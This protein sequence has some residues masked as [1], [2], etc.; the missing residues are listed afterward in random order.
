[1]KKVLVVLPTYNEADNIEPMVGA[2]FKVAAR[3]PNYEIDIL[4]VDDNSPDGTAER[5]ARL[6][7]SRAGLHLIKGCKQGLGKAY[8]RGFKHGLGLKPYFAVVMMDADFSHDPKVIP[9]LL[10]ALEA[11]ADYVIGSRYVA[12]GGTTGNWPTKRLLQSKLANFLAR[13]LVGLDTKVHDLTSG[14]KAVRASALKQIP[15]DDIPA[16]GY[17]FQVSLLHAFSSRGFRVREVPIMFGDRRAGKSK[18]GLRDMAEFLY[19]TYRLN[20]DSRVRR[21]LRFCLVGA[22]GTLVN[23]A[24]LIGLVRL[25]HLP[26]LLAAAIAIEVSIVSN[27]SLNHLY[28][29]R[30]V[31]IAEPKDSPVSLLIKLFRYNLIT[32]S[33]AAI[34]YAVFALGY[35]ML[36]LHYVLADLIAILLATAWNYWMSVRIVW[37]VVDRPL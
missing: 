22:S 7:K 20:P 28:T 16:S 6:Q 33:G 12:G 3:L 32:L 9:A 21:L 11:G 35:K 26:V 29:F 4:V 36:G 34:T 1:M 31:R 18:L 27:F 10:A 30:L 23:L 15:L 19:Q 17:V 5:V 14:F 13:H 25:A 37:R 2:I 8:R 24:V